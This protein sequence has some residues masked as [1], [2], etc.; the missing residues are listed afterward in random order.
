MFRLLG[1]DPVAQA[2]LFNFYQ[3]LL[4]DAVAVARKDGK[5]DDGIT[6]VTGSSVT[7]ADSPQVQP[8]PELLHY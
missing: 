2:D 1:L 6:S 7:L 4:E 5:Y 3:A 8:A